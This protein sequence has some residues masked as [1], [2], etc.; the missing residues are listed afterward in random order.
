[1]RLTRTRCSEEHPL[2]ETEPLEDLL[3]HSARR[4]ERLANEAEIARSL[5]L[6]RKIP[7]ESCALD[8]E[9]GG[10][11]CDPRCHPGW[12]L[13]LEPPASAAELSL[14][15]G[16]RLPLTTSVRASLLATLCPLKRLQDTVDVMRL[17][18]DPNRPRGRSAGLSQQHRY[19][20]IVSSPASDATCIASVGSELGAPRVVVGEALPEYSWS[21]SDTAFPHG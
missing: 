18:L 3:I 9:L 17:L 4:E 2:C 5:L 20:L 16:A 13:Q 1:V 19:R 21:S 11:I 7:L 12:L 8:E 10:A 15:L 14:W 6:H